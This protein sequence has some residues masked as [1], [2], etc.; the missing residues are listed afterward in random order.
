[1]NHVTHP[2]SS[3]P[4][5][6]SPISVVI[7]VYNSESTLEELCNRLVKVLG[8]FTPDFEIL[9][10]NDGSHDS[11]WE[12]IEQ[13]SRVHPSVRGVNLLRNYG[14]HNALLCGIMEARFGI[15]VTLD[16]DLQQHPEDLPALVGK[17]LQGYDVVYGARTTESHGVWR[18]LAARVTKRMLQSAMGVETAKH[19]SPFRA[20]R[21]PI[22]NAFPRDAGPLVSIDVMLTWGAA[23]YAIVPVQ[24]DPRQQGTSG[25]SLTKL[26]THTMNMVTGFTSLP[27]QAASVMGFCLTFIGILILGY[28]LIQFLLVGSKVP[29]FPFLA[30]IIA[31]FSGTQLFAIGIIGEYLA[32]MH[33]RSMGKPSYVVRNKTEYSGSAN[34]G[35]NQ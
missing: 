22:R 16:D 24:H 12:R 32:R 11:S 2:D 23:S 9:L 3:P 5:P 27:L 6:L 10:I 29:G 15:T 19:V 14:Q 21:T 34:H 28:V 26:I 1:M 33:Q 7:P 13:L 17:L 35:T 8:P 30:S 20:F 25:Y 4:L 18:N 31:L